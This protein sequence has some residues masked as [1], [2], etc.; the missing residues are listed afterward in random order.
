MDKIRIWFK[1]EWAS[2]YIENITKW[3]FEA[4][5]LKIT[6]NEGTYFVATDTIH[7]L[8]IGS[9]DEKDM[10]ED[11]PFCPIC[12]RITDPGCV[13]SCDTFKEIAGKED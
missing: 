13:E 6:N 1:N 3:E 9:M 11:F 7:Y 12:N 8:I 5:Y 4:D 2:K 10:K